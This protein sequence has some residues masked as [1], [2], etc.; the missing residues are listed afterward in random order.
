VPEYVPESDVEKDSYVTAA[1]RR[2]QRFANRNSIKKFYDVQEVDETGIGSTFI[3]VVRS[4][5]AFQ[6][7]D[8]G[9]ARPSSFSYT[10]N[11]SLIMPQHANS[12]GIT[13]GV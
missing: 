3:P 8:N 2:N 6:A 5:D 10:Q 12:I 11:T 9:T 7:A 1:S 4:C 13:F